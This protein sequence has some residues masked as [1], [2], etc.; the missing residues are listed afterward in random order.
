MP[1][2]WGYEAIFHFTVSS[3]NFERSLAFYQELGFQLLRDNRDI[4][5]P[6]FVP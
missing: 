6:D 1:G 3:T 4:V 2:D 5:G